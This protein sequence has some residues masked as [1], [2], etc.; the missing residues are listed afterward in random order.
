MA[1]L[2]KSPLVVAKPGV[3][4]QVEISVLRPLEIL[5]G[6]LVNIEPRLLKLE[7]FGTAGDMEYTECLSMTIK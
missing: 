1:L 2:G 7:Y 5:Y 6:H 3:K 4:A